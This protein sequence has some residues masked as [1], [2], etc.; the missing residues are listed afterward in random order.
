MPRKDYNNPSRKKIKK[1]KIG[2][3]KE[4]KNLVGRDEEKKKKQL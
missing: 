4:K 2:V 1:K 3:K